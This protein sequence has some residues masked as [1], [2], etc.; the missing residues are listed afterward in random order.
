MIRQLL[1]F[2]LLFSINVFAQNQ[3]QWSFGAGGN[4]VAP[5]SGD[6]DF[7]ANIGYFAI[8][9]LMMS[10]DFGMTF[11]HDYQQKT[12]TN[13]LSF[14]P[15]GSVL[16]EDGDGF[17]DSEQVEGEPITMTDEG[18][19]DWGIG[20]RY[21]LKDNLFF[22][23]TMATGDGEDPDISMGAGVSLELAFDGRL[24][25]E[26]MIVFS[27]PGHEYSSFKDD[28]IGTESQNTLGLAWQFRYTF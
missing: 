12:Y 28:K 17:Q 9:G 19:F 14:A 21:Y 24:W 13:E 1:C 23:G 3:G 15:D 6:E 27:M 26:P 20:L 2:F 10:F 22:E 16:D 4:F 18:D 25:F 7:N 8:D 11:D 5:G